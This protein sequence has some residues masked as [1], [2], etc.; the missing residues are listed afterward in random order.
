[1]NETCNILHLEDDDNDSLF[2][3]RALT[4]ADFKGAY[5]RVSTV[6]EAIAYFSGGN[7]FADRHLYP[8]PDILVADN[9]MTTMKSST[10]LVDWLESKPEF[11]HVTKVVLTG[12]MSEPDQKR[13]EARGM[14]VLFKGNTVGE[15]GQ[16]VD[17]I[18]RRGTC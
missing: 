14:T 17:E 7:Q 5:R 16:A 18:L 2:F 3:Q 8:L 11:Q 9:A 10:S 4:R 1:M 13:W 6:E 12:D 15:L